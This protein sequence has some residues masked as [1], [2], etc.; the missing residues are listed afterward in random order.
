MTSSA[1]SPT[2]Q[3]AHPFVIYLYPWGQLE[4]TAL[5]E[6]LGAREGRGEGGL[7]CDKVIQ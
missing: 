3:M 1:P 2:Y 6:E 7:G 5:G 4:T